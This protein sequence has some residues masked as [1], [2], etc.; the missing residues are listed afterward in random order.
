MPWRDPAG[1]FSAFKLAVFLLLFLPAILI[2]WR[3]ASG[4]LGARPVNEA[5]HQVGNWTLRLIVLSLAV[6]PLRRIL[7]WPRLL[8][9][10][11]MVGVAAFA[12]ALVHVVLYAADE[13]FV[14]AKVALEI[15]LRIYLAIGLVALLVLAA[16][17][18]T[19]TDG[20][21]RR[22]GGRTW[23]RLHRLV[24]LAAF[25]SVIH[26]FMQAKFDVS[27]CWVMA[28]LFA[29]LM[30]CRMPVP[31]AFRQRRAAPWWPALLAAAAALGT[32]AGETI[33]YAIKPGVPVLRVL[34]AQLAFS[35]SVRPAWIVLAICLATIIAGVARQARPA[36]RKPAPA[37]R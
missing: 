35:P 21:M 32:V 18:A 24:Y 28:G 33:Y 19:S 22:M 14:M 7:G 3:F 4:A 1:R 26:F 10:R 5:V 23:Q 34:E 30:A 9:V 16:L 29:W 20:M 11:R 6:T 31:G 37:A 12:Y 8:L 36:P 2:A 27:E 13:N 15:V 17:A 25:L